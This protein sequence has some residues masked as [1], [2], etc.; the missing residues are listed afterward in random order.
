MF[1][2]YMELALRSLMRNKVLTMLMIIALALGIGASIT[3]LTLFHLLSSD[4]IPGK[5]EKLFYPQIDPRLAKGDGGTDD[6]EPLRLMTYTD[7]IN[8]LGARKATYQAAMALTWTKVT[9]GTAESRP[10]FTAALMSTADFF[11]MFDTQF[12][13]GSGWSRGDEDS[14]ARVVV[15]GD[16]LNEKLFKGANSVGQILRVGDGDFRIVGVLKPWAPQP[17]FYTTELSSRNFGDAT[18]V[19]LPLSTARSDQMQPITLG[20]FSEVAD[21]TK[22]ETAPCYWLGFWVELPDAAAARDYKVFLANYVHQQVALGRMQRTHIELRDLMHWLRYIHVVP[23]DVRLQTGLAFGFLLICIVNTIGLLLAKCLRRSQEIGLRRALGATRKTIFSQFMVEAG[24]IGLT[25]GVL[26]LAFAELGLWG[27]RHQPA[28]YAK[29][30]HL[31]FGM[32]AATF[33]I[34]L[35]SSVIA[36]IFPAWRASILAPALQLKVA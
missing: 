1:V 6:N 18:S 3:T 4:P 36:G 35:I 8:L 28:E 30:A 21:T 29:L 31:D 24:M 27:I 15:I 32:F 14:R 23:N 9:P 11:P 12:H 20:C 33:A 2:Y 16:E 17:R 22:L 5:S 34:A 26:G 13:Y 25:G 7:A 19:F 10:F